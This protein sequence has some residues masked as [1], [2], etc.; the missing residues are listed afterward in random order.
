M[1]EL[2]GGDGAPE[3]AGMRAHAPNTTKL[4][5]HWGGGVLLHSTFL[6]HAVCV[7]EMHHKTKLLSQQLSSSNTAPDPEQ[8][9][10]ELCEKLWTIAPT[11]PTDAPVRM[12]PPITSALRTL[13]Y[14]LSH[15]TKDS[16]AVFR[17]IHMGNRCVME[18]S[19]RLG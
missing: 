1:V 16:N 9:K 13:L 19:R 3:A 2:A 5:P 15:S 6:D 8:L 4:L 17:H 7:Y 14:A 18:Q 10:I 12:L 11:A